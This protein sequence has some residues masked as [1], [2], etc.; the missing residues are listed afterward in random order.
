MS[1]KRKKKRR[2]PS[3]SNKHQGPE[4]YGPGGKTVSVVWAVVLVLIGT[5]YLGCQAQMMSQGYVHIP[6]LWLVILVILVLMAVGMTVQW[7]RSNADKTPK[8]NSR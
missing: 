7:Y 1:A 5:T 2:R 3:R 4:Y 8:D 6:V